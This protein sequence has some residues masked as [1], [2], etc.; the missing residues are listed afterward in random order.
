[1]TERIYTSYKTAVNWLNGNLILCDGIPQIDDSIWDEIRFD[2]DDEEG[3]CIDIYQFFLS[4][5]SKS[6]VE[7]LEKTFGLLFTYSNLLGL[8]VL[9]VD[10]FGTSW[11]DVP[12]EVTNPEWIRVNADKYA[13]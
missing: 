11:E 10:H 5:Y 12:V 8:Y 2:L 3:N 7:W 6:D 13:I 1:M 4:S 9:C